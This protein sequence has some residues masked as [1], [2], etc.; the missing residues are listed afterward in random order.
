[1]TAA[2]AAQ[3]TLPPQVLPTRQEAMQAAGRFESLFVNLLLSRMKGTLDKGFFGGAAGG[4]LQEG[5]FSTMLAD[6]VATEG[7]GLGLAARLV[8][9][10]V[11]K[12]YVQGGEKA[13][14]TD[15]N[16]VIAKREKQVAITPRRT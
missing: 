11:A 1:M 16:T 3:A 13:E 7:P 8:E 12:G 4:H 6:Q 14:G 2:V 9:D 5:L 15:P 10:W